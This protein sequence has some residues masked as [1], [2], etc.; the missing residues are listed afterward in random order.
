ME[1]LLYAMVATYTAVLMAELI[2]DRSVYSIAVL[3]TRF[4]GRTVLTG[5]IPAFALKALAAVLFADT[6]RHLGRGTVAAL[7]ASTFAFAAYLL[8][9]R[10]DGEHERER[11]PTANRWGAATAFGTIFLSEWADAGQ[12]ATA[13]MAAR[14]DPTAT[15]VAAT[16]A[17]T[18][19]AVVASSV[20]ARL[21]PRKEWRRWR[22][23]G[24]GLFLVFGV[25]ALFQFD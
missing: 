7:S 5:V 15:W 1:H 17:F 21:R 16:L 13:A 12:L 20:G 11:S 23:A 22:L 24:A 4:G 19:K 6:L 14:F 25:L 2:G 3:A 8:Y 10:S 9:R 18:T